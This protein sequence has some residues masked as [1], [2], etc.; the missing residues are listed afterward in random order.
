MRVVVVGGG[1]AGL[2]CLLEL[3]RSLPSSRRILIDPGRY[4]VKAT[5]LHEALDRPLEGLR[6]DFAD[7]GRRYG[8]EHRRERLSLRPA[9]L[10]KWAAAGRLPIG[11][12]DIHFDAMVVAVGARPAPRPAGAGFYGIGDLRRIEGLGLVDRICQLNSRSWVTVV[13]GGATG[14]QYLFQLRDAMRRAGARCGLRLVDAGDRLLPEQPAAFHRYILKRIEQSGVRY[15]PGLRLDETSEGR[16]TL[17]GPRGGVQQLSS[18]VSLV[19][20]GLVG[21][22]VFLD[23]DETGRLRYQDHVTPNVFVAGDCSDY[24]GSGLNEKSAQAAVRKGRHV[25]GAIKRLSRGREPSAYR[26]RNLGFFLSMGALDGVGWMGRR[27]TVLTGVPAF[28]VR[29]AIEARYDLYVAGVD[30]Y[31]VL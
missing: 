24:D 8:F 19:F 29:E 16:I 27:A 21:N 22:P 7:L 15:L 9:A 14:L 20:K 30:A 17:R 31:R 23:A 1:Y 18:A 4:H 28:A 3:K 6:Q 10:A 25:A 12:E 5:R 13:G 11:D 26:A 2:A